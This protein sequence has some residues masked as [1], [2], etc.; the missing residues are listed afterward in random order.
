MTC[1][2]IQCLVKIFPKLSIDANVPEHV[3]NHFFLIRPVDPEEIS[4][5]KTEIRLPDRIPFRTLPP[6]ANRSVVPIFPSEVLEGNDP[7]DKSGKTSM[8]QIF[9][10]FKVGAGLAGNGFSPDELREPMGGIQEKT[11]SE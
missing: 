11:L 8:G 6:D 2:S 4:G 7:A 3:F 9:A 5:Q 1:F 10:V